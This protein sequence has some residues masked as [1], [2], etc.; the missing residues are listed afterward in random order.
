L[1]VIGKERVMGRGEK[2][3]NSGEGENWKRESNGENNGEGENWKILLNV[4]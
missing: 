2:G 4:M 3:E 1:T